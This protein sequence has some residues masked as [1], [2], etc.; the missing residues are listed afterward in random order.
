MDKAVYGSVYRSVYESVRVGGE[1]LIEKIW[2]RV[3]PH[4][5]HRPSP[6]GVSPSTLASPTKAWEGEWLRREEGIFKGEAYTWHL[7]VP[8]TDPYMGE[9]C[10]CHTWRHGV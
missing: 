9:A 8:Y 4:E 1:H 6:P 2:L 3:S 5:A 7:T 10:S